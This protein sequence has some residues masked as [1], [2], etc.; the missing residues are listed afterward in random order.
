LRALIDCGTFDTRV[1]VRISYRFDIPDQFSLCTVYGIECKRVSA[2]L[3]WPAIAGS[4][5]LSSRIS[6]IGAQTAPDALENPEIRV[7]FPQHSPSSIFLSFFP[8]SSSRRG[9]NY[10][11]GS[12]RARASP[13]N[14]KITFLRKSRVTTLCRLM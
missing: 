13:R 2:F 6:R 7:V 9:V 10:R 11:Q 8:F 5:I 12:P 1:A 3:M 4:E 14:T